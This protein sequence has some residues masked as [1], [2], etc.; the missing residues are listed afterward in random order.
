MGI[1]ISC[2]GATRESCHLSANE[3][4]LDEDAE[5]ILIAAAKSLGWRQRSF[6]LF[7]DVVI[8]ARDTGMRNRREL[9][10]MRNEN[11]DW[12]NRT[13]FVPDSK[14]PDGRLLR[15][16]RVQ[17]LTGSKVC[18]HP[19]FHSLFR[20]CLRPFHLKRSRHSWRFRVGLAAAD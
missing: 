11:L 18:P 5:E 20:E 16:L 15:L 9:Y 3:C 4:H 2:Q 10:R 19:E 14:T 8:L 7:R 6:E 1:R 12:K 13:I 17:T